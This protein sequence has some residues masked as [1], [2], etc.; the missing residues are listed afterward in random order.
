M[1]LAKT[2]TSKFCAV[3][4][5]ASVLLSC[6]RQA[7]TMV[8]QELK[9]SQEEKA[10]E[11]KIDPIQ[12]VIDRLILGEKIPEEQLVKELRNREWEP[13]KK[14]VLASI[15]KRSQERNWT[16]ETQKQ[17]AMALRYLSNANALIEL[18][19]SKQARE[20]SLK[21]MS[22]TIREALEKERAG[23]KRQ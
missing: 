8:V 9:Q 2:K 7:E 10:K 3:F 14:L 13:V 23:K 4:L 19:K 18:R 12:S 21:E 20:E 11:V 22:D 6:D 15:K 5:L 1:I 16:K 17:A